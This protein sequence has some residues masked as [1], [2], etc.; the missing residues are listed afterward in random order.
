MA[1]DR[2][3]VVNSTTNTPAN[4]TAEQALF[5]K[6]YQSDVI[7]AFNQT[8]AFADRVTRKTITSGTGAK[9]HVTGRTS[10]QWFIPG[11]SP[12]LGGD[13][14][15]PQNVTTINVDR[16]LLSDIYV[17]EMD[18]L[19]ADLDVR[20][21][22]SKEQGRAIAKKLDIILAVLHVLA[23]R[24]TA[25]VTGMPVGGSITGATIHTDSS[26][27]LAAIG[28]GMARFETNDVPVDQEDV[29]CFLNPAMYY[30][31]V[32]NPLVYKVNETGGAGNIKTG[33][34]FSYL[35]CMFKK[36]NNLPTTLIAAGAEV[37]DLSVTGYA[38]DFTKTKAVMS[39]KAS[40]GAVQLMNLQFESQWKIEKQAH[41]FV[42]KMAAGQDILRCDTA[43]ELATP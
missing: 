5:V 9:F 17:A 14:S 25:K 15:L 37:G 11:I 28:T 21:L 35:G 34:I 13:N 41:L 20:Q 30:L 26:V 7:A 6:E 19:Q 24:A 3:G 36:T 23:S 27:L 4:L 12:D 40:V 33:Q 43:I 2:L 22:R 32:Q 31:A 39:T 10:A 16:L 29:T 1:L 18:E 38:G 8:T 42:A